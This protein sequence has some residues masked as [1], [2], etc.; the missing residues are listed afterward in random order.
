MKIA[1]LSPILGAEIDDVDLSTIGDG[2]FEMVYRA[3][4]EYGVLR[5][6]GQKLDDAQLEAFSARFG[7]LEKI[8]LR[9]TPE[10]EK[11]MSLSIFNLVSPHHRDGF[12][13]IYL[14]EFYRFIFF[15][16]LPSFTQ[17]VGTE[18]MH[19]FRAITWCEVET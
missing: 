19:Y 1:K 6:R 14:D 3:W 18:D 5:F 16:S 17:V 12:I 7:P 11:K 2:D 9:M 10:Q 13:E 15:E 4:V 8:P